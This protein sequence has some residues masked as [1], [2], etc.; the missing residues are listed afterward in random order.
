MKLRRILPTLLF[1]L[2]VAV[3]VPASAEAGHHHSRSCGH[4]NYN[5][6]YN[7][8]PRPSYHPSYRSYGSNYYRAP[9][10]AYGVGYYYSAPPV[11]Y[12]RPVPPYYQPYYAPA[13]PP[14]VPVRS[15]VH[16]S[17]GLGW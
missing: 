9:R 5:S 10:P 14:Y 3:V 4:S 1:G 17:I 6:R 2:A 13:Y 11:V 8:N 12:Y 7:Y 16:V 15:G